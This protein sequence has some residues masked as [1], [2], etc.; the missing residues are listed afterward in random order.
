MVKWIGAQIAVASLE[1][2]IAA[3]AP[4]GKIMNRYSV[5]S[6]LYSLH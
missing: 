1:K 4:P 2:V 6:Y 5:G 3:A